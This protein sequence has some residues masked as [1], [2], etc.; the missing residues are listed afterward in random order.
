MNADSVGNP[1]QINGDNVNSTS[2]E[3]NDRLWGL[4]VTV[5]YLIE[6]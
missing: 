5:F 3:A 6:K 4:V 1:S 2:R